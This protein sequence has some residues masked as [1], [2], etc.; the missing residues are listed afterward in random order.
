[1]PEWRVAH[2]IYLP[3][4]PPP[5]S[6]CYRNARGPGRAKTKRYEQWIKQCWGTIRGNIEMVSGD[7][8]VTYLYERPDRR[9]RDL[10]N[11]EKATSDLLTGLYIKDD[12]QIVH[13]TLMWNERQSAP[14]EIIIEVPA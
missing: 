2:L 1:M 13:M 7:T 3:A 11:L 14:L 9:A 5:L 6:A 8:K 12:S 4:I 10:G